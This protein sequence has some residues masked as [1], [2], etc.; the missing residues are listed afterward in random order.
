VNDTLRRALADA[1][2]DEVAVATALSVDP[3]T[4][5][6]WI[7]G[8]LP[9]R[10]HRWDLADMVGRNERELWPELAGPEI[11]TGREIVA[12]YSHRGAVP[13]EV[14]RAL[15]A[16]ARHEIG[17]LVYAG[18]FLAEDVELVR[19]LGEQ[20]RAGVAV[21]ILLGDPDSPIV[22]ERGAEEGIGDAIAAKIRN[23]IVLCRPLLTEGVQVRLH[24]T[25][26]YNS[27]Y[28]A[29]DEILV[30]AHVYGAAAAHA[31]VLHLRQRDPGDLVATYLDSFE[32]V[33]GAAAPLD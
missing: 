11:H 31:P 1:R 19:V 16:G 9:H 18:L 25:I 32:R 4:V 20:A 6:R 27:I 24:R 5:K 26:L 33:W 15:F 30:N 22:G 14:W 17:V 3:K 28:R 29:D 8:R 23:T 7:S 13:R 10:R 2:L 12:A 21:R